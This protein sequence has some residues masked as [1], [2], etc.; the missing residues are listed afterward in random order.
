MASPVSYAAL[1]GSAHPHPQ[2]HTKLRP[3]DAGEQL[4]VTLMLRRKPGHVKLKPE[5]MVADSKARPSRD[6]F[7]A[8]RGADPSELEKVVAAVKAADLDVLEADA[9][10]RS[11]V[12]RGSAATINKA[13]K[14][15]LNDYKYEHGTYRS[16]DGAVNLPSDVAPY[17]EAV[18]GLTNRKVRAKHFSTAS[19]ARRRGQLDPLNTK[20]LTPAQVA[21]LY[22]FPPGDGAGQT[23]G[24]YEMETGDGP[25][26]YAISDIRA[27]MTA[28]GNLPLPKIVDVAIDG[29]GNSEQSDGE[30][31][32]DITVA[33]A[34]APKATIAVYFAGAET[35]NM[36]HAL[37]KMIH[38]KGSDPVPSV[39]SISYGW[40]ADDIGLS[41]SFSESEWNQ[42]T[43]LFEDA[44]TNKIT[45]FVSSGDSGA[46]VES[47]T[48]AQ[49]SYPG[50][51]VWVTSCGGTSIGNVNG[52]SFDEWV[53]NDVGAA[54]PGATGGGVSARFG[55][56]DYQANAG[57][58]VRN[59]TRTPGRGVPDIA[60][61][62]SENSGYLQVI[63][64][65]RPESVGGTSAVAPLY[66]GLMARINANNKSPAG[67]LN[68]TLYKLASSAFRDV[69]GAAGPANNSFNRVSGYPAGAGWD[70]C[71]GLGSVN[72]QALQAA[73]AA[74]AASAPATS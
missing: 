11:V 41:D 66:A 49:V 12:V 21:T 19:A 65:R 20:P 32:L 60:G 15:Q 42:F 48:Q 57:V 24:L 50:S 71:T 63:N 68:T 72:G 62:A 36:I 51:D 56:P 6:A 26:G 8:T 7:A 46:F 14:I 64:G 69:V 73:L 9:A 52:S 28:L 33:A 58:P 29:T 38:P 70:A 37:Q 13:F 2:E 45:V 67:Y 44:A 16:H 5:A 47:N 39:I 25:A 55:L 74:L 54:G 10:R 23:I 40:G 30:T 27:T 22:D 31:G 59:S 53:W 35:Q 3:T 4:T 61:N 34:I 43:Q 17:V 1:A 18:V